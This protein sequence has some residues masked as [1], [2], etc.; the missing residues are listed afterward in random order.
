MTYTDFLLW[1][2]GPAFDIAII[3]FVFGIILRLLEIFLLG[4]QPE[5]AAV[6]NNGAL[7]GLKTIF[8]RFAPADHN[9]FKRSLFVVIM[10]YVFHLGLF[11]T[12]LFFDPHIVLF[13]ATFG[14]SWPGLPAPVIN[15]LTVMS[16]LAMIALLINRLF[17][18]VLRFLSGF[19]DY[20]VWTVTFL[21]L[22]T[23]YMAFHHLLL[24]YPLMLALHILSVEILMIVLP[25]TK[26]MHTITFI[27]ARWFNGSSA[28]QKGVQA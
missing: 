6:R 18:P 16:L 25:F 24:P 7:G 14:F 26:L 28:A 3:I 8:R 20:L 10:G 2:R 21:P 22:L 17:H 12:I 19:E 15:I 1:V 27:M 23:G 9:T 5:Y 11:I 4:R 13:Q